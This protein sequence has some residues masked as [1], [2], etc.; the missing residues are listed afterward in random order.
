MA[1]TGWE[2]GHLLIRKLVCDNI[3]SVG[4]YT[5]NIEGKTY[6]S[7]SK[8]KTSTTFATDVEIMA[9]AQVLGTDIYVYHTYGDKLRWLRFACVHSMMTNSSIYLDNRYGNGKTGHFDYVTGLN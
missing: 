6:L 3:N 5:K 8:M 2:V 4:P 9:A 1:V 7:Q